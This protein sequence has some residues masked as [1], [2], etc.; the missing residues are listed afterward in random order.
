MASYQASSF[1]IAA[2]LLQLALIGGCTSWVYTA[3]RALAGL[4]GSASASSPSSPAGLVIAD[5]RSRKAEE[6]TKQVESLEDS[7]VEED[8]ANEASPS[9]LKKKIGKILTKLRL[10]A[11]LKNAYHYKPEESDPEDTT[12]SMAVDSSEA[13]PT[14]ASAHV[15]E[16]IQQ[17]P[18]AAP[19]IRP[20]VVDLQVSQIDDKLLDLKEEPAEKPA[21]E[22]RSPLRSLGVFFAE[23]LGS[24]VGLTY[25]AVAQISAGGQ[26]PVA[27]STSEGL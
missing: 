22:A 4:A 24:I 17:I 11:Q 1:I 10:I 19:P 18:A 7:G 23:L 25:G 8:T 21:E 20:L 15:S 3:P 14:D 9:L 2:V 5:L 12:M 6:L 13:Q 16:N 27:I 26:S